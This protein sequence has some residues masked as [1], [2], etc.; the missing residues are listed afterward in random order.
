MKIRIALLGATLALAAGPLAGLALAGPA[1]AAPLAPPATCPTGDTCVSLP[2]PCADGV[3]PTAV[4]GPTSGISD[5]TL[6]DPQRVFVTLYGFPAG[7]VPSVYFC[8]DTTPLSSAPP[9]CLTA[10][11]PVALPVYADG[12]T[13]GSQAAPEDERNGNGPLSGQVPRGTTQGTFYCD[14]GADTC[15]IDVFDPALRPSHSP[16]TDDTL[17]APVR[18]QPDSAGCPKGT[19]LNTVSDF[20]I[21]GLLAA[22]APL[23]CKGTIPAIALNTA[24]N[25]LAAVQALAG[26]QAD[27]AFTDDPEAADEQS[28]LKSTPHAFIPV[29]ATAD[30]FGFLAD[31]TSMANPHLPPY[32]QANWS[33]TPT[34]AA[35]LVADLDT[36]PGT[37]DTV[38]AACA[39]PS[40]ASGQVS[41]C[42]LMEALNAQGGFLPPQAYG[43]YVRADNAGVTDELLSWLCT[44][45]VRPVS[46]GGQSLTE[47][48]TG[49]QVLS[50]SNQWADPKQDGTCPRTDQFPGVAQQVDWG[51]GPTPQDQFKNL[52]AQYQQAAPVRQADF[53]VLNWY[54]ALHLGLGVAALQNDAGAFVAPTAASVDAGL[55]G[56]AHNPDGTVTPNYATVSDP[57]AY[58]MPAVIYAVVPTK[59]LSADKEGSLRSV[60][61]ALLSQ[62]GGAQASGLP[63]GLVGLPSDLTAEAQHL[64]ETDLPAEVPGGNQPGGGGPGTPGGSLPPGI[65]FGYTPGLYSP[66]ASFDSRA[67]LAR[68]AAGQGGTSA[69]AGHRAGTAD[70]FHAAF[71]ALTRPEDSWL[72]VA[73]LLAGGAAAVLGTLAW[74][75]LGLG[76]AEAVGEGAEVEEGAQR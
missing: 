2:A 73:L 45:P 74:G 25:S 37:T 23:S 41:P 46:L 72:L 1:G 47:T 54:E 40:A 51:A 29:V 32:P 59:G 28:A 65:G 57:T 15:S 56:A 60:L 71:L 4:V 35:G 33:L 58:A 53:G 3:C 55:A 50:G 20:G 61:L 18:F 66:V 67:A 12:S 16:N 69:G 63:P 9:L 36:N 76:R 38:D 26:G 7:D 64:I 27:L 24:Q 14:N 70:P 13:A 6:T 68:Q 43:A 11:A 8:A 62:T 22:V 5:S 17:V 52:F 49:A 42:P 30:V 44:A 34:M 10:P 75:L 19:I 48:Q 31:D 39:N 21:E